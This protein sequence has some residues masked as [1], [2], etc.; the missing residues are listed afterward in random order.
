MDGRVTVVGAGVIGLT[1]AVRLAET[2]LEVDVLARDLPAE[3]TSAVAGGLWLPYLAEPMAQVARWSRTSL[4]VFTALAEGDGPQNPASS[5]VRI[6]PGTLLH[7]GAVAPPA[8]AETMSDVLRLTPVRDPAP[9]YTFGHRLAVPL[10]DMPRYLE[11]LTRRLRAA[12]GTLTRLSLSTLPGR[13]IVINCT[14]VAARALACDPSVRAVRGQTV[15][16]SDP[17]LSEWFCDEYGAELTYVLP[18]GRDV[19]VGGTLQDGDWGTT[20]DGAIARSIVER[21]I[22]VA[23][24]LRGARVLGHRVGLRPVRPMVR[25]ET[26]MR[27]NDLDARHAVVH[28]YGHGG[29]GVTMSWGCADDVVNAVSRLAAEPVTKV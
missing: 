14:G 11:Y 3:T 21:A 13:G 28:C 6:M 16:L 23:P 1:C 5:G 27:P 4:T 2:G 20:P 7:H 9:G 10:I 25:V 8:W 15:L 22:A 19:V 18:R 26:E 29:S 12:N 17:G 24:A